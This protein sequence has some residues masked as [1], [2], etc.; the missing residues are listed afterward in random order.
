MVSRDMDT[1]FDHTRCPNC[2]ARMRLAEVEPPPVRNDFDFERHVYQC[3]R[4]SN[5]SRFVIDRK[6]RPETMTT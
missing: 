6:S 4:C 1:H 2:D 3:D 5:L